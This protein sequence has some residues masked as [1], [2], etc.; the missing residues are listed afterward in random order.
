M[1]QAPLFQSLFD[2]NQN[3]ISI[4][5]ENDKLVYANQSYMDSFGL[6]TYAGMTWSDVMI[7]AYQHQKGTNIE[8]NDIVAWVQDKKNRRGKDTFRTFELDFVDGRWILLTQ[9]LTADNFLVCIAVDVSN[10][11]AE[12]R[13][14]RISRDLALRESLTDSLTKVSNRRHIFSILESSINQLVHSEQR[15]FLAILDID[16]FKKINDSLGHPFGDLVLQSFAKAISEHIKRSDSVGRVGGEEFIVLLKCA[17]IAQA[18]QAIQRVLD[19]VQTPVMDSDLGKFTYSF[20]A[21]ITP[22]LTTDSPN[23][24][25]DRADKLLLQ[26][27]SDGRARIYCSKP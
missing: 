12:E 21:G 15:S 14:L 25:Y 9:Q 7:H 10:F 26:A 22:L 1:M 19:T 4:F 3:L 8:T 16:F 24:A 23:Q 27:K 18:Q 17:N 13:D 5:D 20:S 11:R 2:D 6:D